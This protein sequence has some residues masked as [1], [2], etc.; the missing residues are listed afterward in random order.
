VSALAAARNTPAA[1]R[2]AAIDRFR[3]GAEETFRC[4]D[5][6]DDDLRSPSRP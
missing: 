3:R 2:S 5:L 1:E 4:A 6:G